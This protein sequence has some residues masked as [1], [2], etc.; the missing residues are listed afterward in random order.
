MVSEGIQI[1][2]AQVERG[3]G[4]REQSVEKQDFISGQKRR[5]DRLK[6][7][8]CDVMNRGENVKTE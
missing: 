2:R 7:L 4:E 8:H 1:N 6:G 3:K 5:A